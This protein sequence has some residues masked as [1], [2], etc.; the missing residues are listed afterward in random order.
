MF[1]LYNRLKLNINGA[2]KIEEII[3]V[4]SRIYGAGVNLID[5]KSLM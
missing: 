3:H 4:R 5:P 2:M 1:E